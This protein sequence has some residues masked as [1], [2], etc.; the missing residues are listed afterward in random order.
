MPGLKVVGGLEVLSVCTQ[1]SLLSKSLRG[2]SP[3]NNNY[4]YYYKMCCK[5]VLLKLKYDRIQTSHHVRHGMGDYE[6][7]AADEK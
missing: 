4:S 6:L 1:G 2:Y 7:K 3:A 5:N